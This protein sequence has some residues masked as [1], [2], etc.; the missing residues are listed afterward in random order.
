MRAATATAMGELTGFTR[1]EAHDATQ[2]DS[3]RLFVFG[4]ERKVIII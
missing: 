3:M 1:D 2:C 4:Q